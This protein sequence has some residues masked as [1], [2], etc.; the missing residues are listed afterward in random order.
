MRVLSL[1]TAISSLAE[2]AG[3]SCKRPM[4]GQVRHG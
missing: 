1:F 3:P 2:V 4:Q